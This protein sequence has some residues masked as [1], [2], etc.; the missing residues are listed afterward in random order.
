MNHDYKEINLFEVAPEDEHS[1]IANKVW[2]AFDR[3]GIKLSQDAELSIKVY[4]P[5]YDEDY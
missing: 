3:A 1:H 4:E 5:I 2:E